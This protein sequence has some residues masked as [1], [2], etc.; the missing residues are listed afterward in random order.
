MGISE[1]YRVSNV[2]RA[3]ANVFKEVV[4]GSKGCVVCEM[5]KAEILVVGG[6]YLRSKACMESSS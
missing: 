4:R 6:L 1:I 5:E 3:V 2:F